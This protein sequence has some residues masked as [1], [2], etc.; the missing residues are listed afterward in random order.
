MNGLLL[1]IRDHKYYAG[2][3]R[4]RMLIKIVW[5]LPRKL[6][7]WSAIRVVAHA[8]TGKYSRQIVPKLTAM[9][10]LNRWDD[11][12]NSYEKPPEYER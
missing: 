4:E 8:T 3:F 7:M 2:K 1:R 9:D 12:D 6:V 11:T 5:K 10:A